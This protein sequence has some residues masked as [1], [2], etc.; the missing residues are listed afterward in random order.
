MNIN[1]VTLVG[2]LADNIMYTPEG[3]TH[4]R[5]VGRL[6]IN[7]PPGKDG[8]KSYD[9]IQIVGWGRNADILAQYTSKG[10]EIGIKGEIRV[11]SVAPQREGDEW[12]NYFEV[13]A[14][15]IS[16]GRDSNQA[17]M[18][19][20]LQ[21]GA[22][23]VKGATVASEGN[24]DALLQNP[25]V[26]ELLQQIAQGARPQPMVEEPESASEPSEEANGDTPFS[27]P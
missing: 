24:V 21:G 26:K 12:K 9:A 27:A 10:K 20:A 17:K 18:M 5:A 7:R 11:N 16:L 6:I 14:H 4:A 25:Q 1:Q 22:E 3:T 8:K 2:R 19:K 15:H 23:V 13:V